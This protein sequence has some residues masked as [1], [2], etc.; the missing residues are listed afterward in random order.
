MYI[1]IHITHIFVYVYMIAWMHIYC[2]Y[3]C[4]FVYVCMYMY[5]YAL[6]MWVFMHVFVC[7]YGYVL[8]CLET[9]G[10]HQVSSSPPFGWDSHSLIEPWSWL[11]WL[12][13]LASD[14][15]ESSTFP[16]FRWEYATR[17]GFLHRCW[18]SK[19]RSSC[20][21]CG[22]LTHWAIFPSQWLS[23][24]DHYLPI[25]NHSPLVILPARQKKSFLD[26][27]QRELGSFLSVDD[28]FVWQ[29]KKLTVANLSPGAGGDVC[30]YAHT[31]RLWIQFWSNFPSTVEPFS[32][33]WLPPQCS[34]ET[35]WG[36]YHRGPSAL[37]QLFIHGSLLLSSGESFLVG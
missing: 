9:R 27:N 24:H 30:M 19:L 28:T 25:L 15:Q 2:V 8:V 16:A 32:V 31:H 29:G 26:L 20:F 4:I 5:L 36:C 33:F 11:I 17:P 1:Y 23:F 7:V 13:W 12:D 21:C 3:V 10:Q 34:R 6:C 18:G 14:P 37:P 35:V 22:Y